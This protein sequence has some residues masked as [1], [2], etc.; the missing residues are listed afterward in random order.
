MTLIPLTHV[1]RL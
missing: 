1:I